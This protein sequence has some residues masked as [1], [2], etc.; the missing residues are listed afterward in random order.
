MAVKCISLQEEEVWIYMSGVGSCEKKER[1]LQSLSVSLPDY[2]TLHSFIVTRTHIH[3][4]TGT[5]SWHVAEI[6]TVVLLFRAMWSPT[7]EM[8]APTAAVFADA[9]GPTAKL[10]ETSEGRTA[11]AVGQRPRLKR[12]SAETAAGGGVVTVGANLLQNIRETAR[13]R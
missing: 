3:T 4:H 11:A 1:L 10:G 12:R 7:T 2:H 5:C 6:A 9:A 13:G 8:L